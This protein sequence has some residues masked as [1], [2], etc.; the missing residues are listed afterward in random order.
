MRLILAIFVFLNPTIALSDLSFESLVLQPGKKYLCDGVAA[1]GWEA[2]KLFT[3][4]SAW[5]PRT[6]HIIEPIPLTVKRQ[7]AFQ[8]EFDLEVAHTIKKLGWGDKSFCGIGTRAIYCAQ[9]NND[10]TLGRVTYRL[11]ISDQQEIRF[12]FDRS[13]VATSMSMSNSWDLEEIAIEVG[14]CREF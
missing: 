5:D 1:L 11:A 12:V 9:K 4:P 14:T 13:M 3:E 2:D 7:K 10:G 8:K 6:T